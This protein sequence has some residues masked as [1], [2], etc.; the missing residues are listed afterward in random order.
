MVKGLTTALCYLHN[1]HNFKKEMKGI[2]ATIQEYCIVIGCTEPW[3]NTFSLLKL[4]DTARLF[5]E[6]GDIFVLLNERRTL[7]K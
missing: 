5:K 3:A 4:V 1:L 6:V 7:R 2:Y